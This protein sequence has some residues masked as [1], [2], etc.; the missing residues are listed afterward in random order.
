MSIGVSYKNCVTSNAKS[1]RKRK[2]GSRTRTLFACKEIGKEK[3]LRPKATTMSWKT[4]RNKLRE[5]SRQRF[6]TE[7]AK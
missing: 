6:E 7:S 4:P 3:N 1:F 5:T 2:P